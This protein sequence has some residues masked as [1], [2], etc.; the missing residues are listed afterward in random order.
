MYG[1][2]NIKCKWLLIS[3][4]KMANTLQ[5]P[6]TKFCRITC[7]TSSVLVSKDWTLRLALKI[8]FLVW[9]AMKFYTIL[10]LI[11]LLAAWRELKGDWALLFLHCI[12]LILYS[13]MSNLTRVFPSRINLKVW[14]WLWDP[15]FHL[16]LNNHQIIG[17][18]FPNSYQQIMW[19]Y[20][21][22]GHGWSQTVH[23]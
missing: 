11:M 7:C 4:H 21:N 2:A 22:T 20:L 13:I 12:S 23:S 17:S 9:T 10:R 15:R 3:S 19:Q 8:I 1:Q 16:A 18:P 5:M 6:D 14:L